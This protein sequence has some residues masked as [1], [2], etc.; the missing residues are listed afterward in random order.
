[1]FAV[2][3]DW[4]APGNIIAGTCSR[5]QL[6]PALGHSVAL[7]QVHG[8]KC[9]DVAS[10]PDGVAADAS[11]SRK[12]GYICSVRTAD[13][14]PILLCNTDGSEVAAIHAGWRGLAAG[15]I[16]STLGCLHSDPADMLA[17]LGPAISQPRFEV[18]AEVRE[19]FLAAAAGA[20]QAETAACF[21]AL[22]DKYLADLYALARL[23]LAVAGFSQTWGG[24]H[25][26]YT[27]AGLFHSY[28]RDGADAGRMHTLIM[29]TCQG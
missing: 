5:N 4:P 14:L 17:W 12:A 9:V 2:L 13:C 11:F 6:V 27:E 19:Q 29:I 21:V 8:I 1:V 23:R 26:T 16:E 10:S 3:P 15:V 25:C 7:E 20:N 18:G 24:Q 22:G 28:R